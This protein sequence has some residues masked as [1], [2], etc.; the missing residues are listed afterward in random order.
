MGGRPKDWTLPAHLAES[1]STGAPTVR[2]GVVGRRRSRRCAAMQAG[3]ES[4]ALLWT[5]ERPRRLGSVPAVVIAM[6]WEG[7]PR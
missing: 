3:R 5:A 1:V 4:C 2:G 7:N 6:W